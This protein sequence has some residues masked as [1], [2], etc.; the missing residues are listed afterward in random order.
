MSERTT[1]AALVN[2]HTRAPATAHLSLVEAAS[3]IAFGGFIGS[4][5]LELL[6]RSEI[7]HGK[8]RAG[9]DLDLKHEWS[10]ARAEILARAGRGALTLYGRFAPR[11]GADP[12]G[13]LVQIPADFFIAERELALGLTDTLYLGNDPNRAM[14][15]DVRVKTD[16]FAGVF[17]GA[18][19]TRSATS[20]EKEAIRTYAEEAFGKTHQAPSARE[21]SDAFPQVSRSSLRE[22]IKELPA[23]LQRKIGR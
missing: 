4:D 17:R 7:E 18:K 1:L 21:L 14:Y 6:L 20:D 19:P 10:R 22:T 16:E 5:D 13:E 9:T 2:R 15:Y 3:F 12:I 23:H 11:F 8:E